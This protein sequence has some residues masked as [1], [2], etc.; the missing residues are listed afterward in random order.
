MPNPL[1]TDIERDEEFIAAYRMRN[2]EDTDWLY[3]MKELA[4]RF[5]RTHSR[6]YQILRK[7]GIPMRNP[8]KR[9]KKK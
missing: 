3:S 8:V 2:E 7:Y 4:V 1:T 5:D 6:L 9:K